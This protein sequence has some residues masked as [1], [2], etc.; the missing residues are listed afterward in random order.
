MISINAATSPKAT[1]M[2]RTYQILLYTN[3]K[4][5]YIIGYHPKWIAGRRPFT[6]CQTTTT[7]LRPLD[8]TLPPL[9]ITVLPPPLPGITVQLAPL[10]PVELRREREEYADDETDEDLLMKKRGVISAVTVT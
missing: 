3:Y 4:K 6:C 1:Q 5:G 7:L 8:T 9:V 10:P 2:T